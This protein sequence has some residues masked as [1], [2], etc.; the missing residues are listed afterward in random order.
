MYQKRERAALVFRP[1]A[2]ES[3]DC[4]RRRQLLAF[5]KHSTQFYEFFDSESA[6]RDGIFSARSRFLGGSLRSVACVWETKKYYSWEQLLIL[7]NEYH[8]NRSIPLLLEGE[9]GVYYVMSERSS[10]R[11]KM[12][13]MNLESSR[14]SRG[15]SVCLCVSSVILF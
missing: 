2:L 3:S 5:R 14:P 13:L 4:A 7:C 6:R 8:F 15:K 9:W 11:K 1:L 10:D 12:N